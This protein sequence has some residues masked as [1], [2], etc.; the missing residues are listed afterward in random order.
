MEKV[1]YYKELVKEKL[2]AGEFKDT[3]DVIAYL[4]E[5]VRSEVEEEIYSGVLESDE[6]VATAI[7]AYAHSAAQVFPEDRQSN[8]WAKITHL[9]GAEDLY[10]KFYLHSNTA[11]AVVNE[12]SM[13]IAI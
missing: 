6:W 2:F 10:E 3:K 5:V 4:A 7:L 8:A 11:N 12:S 9:V 13:S 1:E